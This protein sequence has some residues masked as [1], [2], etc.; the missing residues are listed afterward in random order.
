MNYFID[1]RDGQK[2]RTVTMP[3]GR[4][5]MAQNLNYKPKSGK[6]WAYNDDE[7]ITM[8]YG[9]LYDWKTAVKACPK[10]WHLPSEDEFFDMVKSIDETDDN[11]G[12]LLKSKSDWCQ[13]ADGNPC[14]GNGI[15]RYGFTALPGGGR[16]INGEFKSFGSFGMWW[17]GDIQPATKQVANY[18]WLYSGHG[19]AVSYAF[20]DFRRGFS[21]RCIK[22]K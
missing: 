8:H 22:N 20:G 16:D 4:V 19:N 18:F 6:S 15:D 5:W 1:E 7:T 10:G 9:R 3:D 2:Y 12:K 13:D 21:V 11:V 17:G 14:E